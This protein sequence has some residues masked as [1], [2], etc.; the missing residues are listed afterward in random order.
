MCPAGSGQ[1]GKTSCAVA[2]TVTVD[3]VQIEQTQ[4]HVRTSLYIVGKDNMTISL[5]GSVNAANELNRH[6]FM[7]VPMR[8]AHVCSLV[9]QHVVQNGAVAFRNIPQLLDKLREILHVVPID[10]GVLRNTLRLVAVMGRSVPASI[11]PGFGEALACQIAAQHESDRPRDVALEGKRHQ[12]V[13][14]TVMDM[15][16][17]G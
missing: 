1:S 15:L 11:E 13:H 2:E 3:T 12:V 5:E 14:Q 8:I 9:D 6:F 7:S 10:F 16:A 4:Q 17:L